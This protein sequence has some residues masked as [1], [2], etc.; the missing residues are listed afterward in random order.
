[1]SRI[2]KKSVPI[3]SG[4]T[5]NVEDQTVKV[6]AS[7]SKPDRGVVWSKWVA[8]NQ[9][10]ETVCTIEGMGMFARRPGD[11]HDA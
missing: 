4:V 11:A 2:G 1:M 8:I 3:P 7:T 10:G 6:K 5:A 9:H